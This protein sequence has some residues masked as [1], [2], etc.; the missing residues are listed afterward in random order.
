MATLLTDAVAQVRE[1]KQKDARL[2]GAPGPIQ[3]KIETRVDN[4]IA[5]AEADVAFLSRLGP[6]SR[7]EFEGLLARDYLA[8]L[9]YTVA[10]RASEE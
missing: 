4:W 10:T 1:Y 6:R 5:T 8:E 9:W 2:R 3:A 7:C